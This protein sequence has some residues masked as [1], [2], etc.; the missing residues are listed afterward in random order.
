[1]WRRTRAYTISW[2]PNP[3]VYYPTKGCSRLWDA[4]VVSGTKYQFLVPSESVESSDM[5]TPRPV[6]R[7]P[8]QDR[9]YVHLR[10]VPT[11]CFK[12][13]WLQSPSSGVSVYSILGYLCF[14][15]VGSQ[16]QQGWGPHTLTHRNCLEWIVSEMSYYQVSVFT[17]WICVTGQLLGDIDAPPATAERWQVRNYV[18]TRHRGNKSL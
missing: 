4:T 3:F 12:T 10:H 6:S 11:T 5:L 8:T 15:E 13:S 9:M 14:L 18:L 1:M 7:N 2:W 16:G 17:C